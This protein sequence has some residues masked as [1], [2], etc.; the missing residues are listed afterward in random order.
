LLQM[1]LSLLEMP[2]LIQ[3][4]VDAPDYGWLLLWWNLWPKKLH[5]HHRCLPLLVL[6]ALHHQQCSCLRLLQWPHPMLVPWGWWILL[7]CL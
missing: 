5:Q 7:C 1:C 3:P 2:H 4:K 6:L